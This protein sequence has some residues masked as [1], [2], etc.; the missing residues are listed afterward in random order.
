[1]P[2][3]GSQH[4]VFP[5]VFTDG[6][7]WM[8]KVPAIG[9]ERHWQDADAR[10][11]SSEA[12]T[13]RLIKRATTIP[14]P[15]VLWFEGSLENLLRCPFILMAHVE[16]ISLYEYWFDKKV[17][18]AERTQRNLKVLE[19]VAEAML[20][21]DKFSFDQGGSLEF[22]HEGQF[23]GIGP[24]RRLDVDSTNFGLESLHRATE[25]RLDFMVT[26]NYGPYRTPKDFY[27]NIFTR[28]WNEYLPDETIFASYN[29]LELLVECIPEPDDGRKA[30]VL[31]H[32]DL[33]IQNVIISPE[34]GTVLAIID[35]HGTG[36]VPRSMGNESYPLW[37]TRD[38]TASNYQW[39]HP[40][41]PHTGWS[42]FEDDPPKTLENLRAEYQRIL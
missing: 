21:L 14:V 34:D 12:N 18:E 31:A 28:T 5:I 40:N 15:D 3:F 37:L 29:A 36:A 2:I 20:Q 10:G 16:G 13:M 38:W 42:E 41:C 19:Q 33:S 35:W 8:L 26:A 27:K 24:M 11:L 30:F 17:S 32:P 23:L 4:V 6:V 25:S 22:N 1:S 7:Q 39:D 9:V